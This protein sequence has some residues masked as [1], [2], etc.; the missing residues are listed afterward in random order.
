MPTEIEEYQEALELHQASIQKCA[1][2]A[3][4][5]H[6]A[7]KI[8]DN[9]RTAMVSNTDAGFPAELALSGRTP[10]IDAAQWPTA[11]QIGADMAA[12]HATKSAAQ[13]AHSRIPDAQRAVILPPPA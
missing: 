6:H 3:D 13:Q 8:L 9:W 7:S 4:F 5:I 12:Y 1:K 11:Q 2:H 10:T